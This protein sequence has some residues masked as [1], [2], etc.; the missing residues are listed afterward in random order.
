MFTGFGNPLETSEVFVNAA[1][2]KCGELGRRETDTMDTFVDSSWYFFRYCDPHSVDLPY[3]K[4]PVTYWGPV[5]QYIGGIE[6]AILHLLYARFWT[7]FTRDIGLHDFNEPFSNLLTQGMVNKGSPYCEHCLQFL[8]V[9]NYDLKAETCRICG[10]KYIIKSVK[11][12]KSLGNTVSPESIVEKFGADTARFFILLG[13]NP[14]KEL[15]WSDQGVEHA[16]RLLQRTWHLITMPPNKIRK[17]SHIV[18]E[19]ILYAL[20]ITIKQT[21]EALEKLAIRDGLTNIISL[22]DKVR[23]YNDNND[24]GVNQ[25]IFNDCKKNIILLLAP[26]APHFA[27]EL[28]EISGENPDGKRFVSLESWPTFDERFIQVKIKQQW[29]YFDQVVDD[30]RNIIQ[31]LQRDGNERDFKNIHLIVADGWKAAVVKKALEALKE[32]G[33][34][35]TILP[36]IMAEESFQQRNKQVMALL[37]RIKKDPGKFGEAFASSDEELQFLENVKMLLEH[38]FN[39]KVHLE[40]E[41]VSSQKKKSQALPGKPAIL[42]E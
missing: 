7:K 31:L 39:L 36:V 8:P 13:A 28:W 26:F 21:T 24:L 20:H 34:P 19:S 18:D 22:I 9:E 41:A 33:D 1:C 17:E 29:T 38:R 35:Y 27:E 2:P 12:S 25:V 5:D 23:V 16:F 40:A 37:A 4:S 42:I 11:M 10:N 15:E 14:E 3:K 32:N 6:H 30:I